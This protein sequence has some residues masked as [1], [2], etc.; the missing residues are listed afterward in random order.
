MR[1]L[2]H[3]SGS[4]LAHLALPEQLGGVYVVQDND[5]PNSKAAQQFAKAVETLAQRY[6]LAI[7]SMDGEYKDANDA[8]L[9]KRRSA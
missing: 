8:L 5:A 9:G 4:N 2:A 3:V 6:E 7:V 1:V